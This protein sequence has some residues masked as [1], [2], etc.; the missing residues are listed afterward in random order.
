MTSHKINRGVENEIEFKGLKGRYVYI[1][2]LGIGGSLFG[3]I[4]LTII[5]VPNILSSIFA[6]VGAIGT[7]IYA[8]QQNKRNGRWG[9]DKKIA[10]GMYPTSMKRQ[11]YFFDKLV[12]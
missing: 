5:G 9:K 12:K 11:N 8:F 10:Q 2:G 7:T 3:G 4:F 1:S 6:G